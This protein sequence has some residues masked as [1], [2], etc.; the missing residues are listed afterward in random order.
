MKMNETTYEYRH[1]YVIIWQG[2]CCCS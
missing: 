1:G 2:Y